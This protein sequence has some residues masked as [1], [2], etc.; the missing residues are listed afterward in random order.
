MEAA[1]TE[2]GVLDMIKG[3][4]HRT[5]TRQ[6][7]NQQLFSETYLQE[8]RTGKLPIDSINA[9]RQTM[10]EW[11]TEY[12]DLEN[13]KSLQLYVGQ[14]LSTLELPYTLE[15]MYLTLYSDPTHV[16]PLGICMMVNDTDIGRMTKGSHHQANLVK[17]LR[18]ASLR[19]GMLT[20]GKRWRL[21]YAAAAAPYEVFLEVDLDSILEDTAH[22]DLW[23]FTLF[24]GQQAFTAS[25]STCTAGGSLGLDQHIRESEKR[26]EAIQRYLRNSIESIVKSLCLGFVQDEAA[27]TYTDKKL[28]EIYRNC[29]IVCFSFFMRKRAPSC[30]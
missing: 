18:S 12:P 29:S 10:R 8:L 6:V 19:W 14:C 5:A 3:E 13:Y 17:Q 28:A 24:F 2:E 20:N 26:T 16:Q 15:Q 30:Q 27:G 25:P 23:L 7:I 1:P 22:T 9:C 21:C 11:R 4:Y